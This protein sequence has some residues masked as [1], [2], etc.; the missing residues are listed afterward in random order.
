MD[1]P[2]TKTH[3]RVLEAWAKGHARQAGNTASGWRKVEEMGFSVLL[4]H[5]NEIARWAFLRGANPEGLCTVHINLAGWPT[6]TTFRRINAALRTFGIKGINV[7][8]VARKPVM[9]GTDFTLHLPRAGW[10]T[11]G[12]FQHPEY[13]K[14][15]EPWEP[16]EQD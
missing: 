5:G 7:G 12:T 16:W 9:R 4:L 2:N 11:V 3:A 8:S 6:V 1:Y 14:P 15:R 13:N 10:I